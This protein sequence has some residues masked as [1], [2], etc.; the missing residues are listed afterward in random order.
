MQRS[1]WIVTLAALG[2]GVCPMVGSAQSAYGPRS[3]PVAR[4]AAFARSAGQVVAGQVTPPGV[5]RRAS[6]GRVLPYSV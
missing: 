4:E 2:S 1:F 5:R 3:L 6:T